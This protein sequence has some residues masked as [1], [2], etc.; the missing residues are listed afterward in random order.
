[1]KVLPVA[2]PV[3]LASVLSVAA[4][5][6]IKP[7]SQPQFDALAASGNPIVLAIHADWCPTCKAQ[8]PILDAL[9]A[10]PAFK[11]VTTLTIDFDAD[12]ALLARYR[13]GMQSTL[14]A[15]KGARELGRSVGDTTPA[16][17]EGLIHKT[18]D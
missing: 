1:V 10:R 5:G 7:Y 15:F 4:A 17:I 13:V 6:E 16:G 14:I 3:L 12:K 11:D 18:V 9:M 8:K 2:L